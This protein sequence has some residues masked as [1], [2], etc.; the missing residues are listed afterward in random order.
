[1]RLKIM[2]MFAYLAIVLMIVSI[3]PAGAFAAGND[4]DMAPRGAGASND[5]ADKNMTRNQIRDRVNPTDDA[6]RNEVA[7]QTRGAIQ[8]DVAEYRSAKERIVT[9][10]N[11]YSDAKKDFQDIRI[12]INNKK[13]SADSDEVVEATRNYMNQTIEY[14]ITHLETVKE[15]VD[16]ADGD[17]ADEISETIDGYIEQ[18]Q[19]QQEKLE[20]ASTRQEF[21]EIAK[22][23]RSI[24]KDAE[25]RA[26]YFAGKS[27][28]RRLDNYLAKSDALALRIG[29]EI[30]RL[31][32]SGEDVGDLEEM[33]A[34][35][36][37]LIEE[38][39][40]NQE[41]ARETIRNRNGDDDDAVDDANKYMRE[42]TKNI[43][44]ANRV[45]KEIF[46]EL[47]SHRRGGSA[48]LDGAGTLTTEGNGTAV[49]S[50]NLNITINATNAKL[51]I[52]DLA[53]DAEINI[54]GDYTL[55]ND[56]GDDDNNRALVYH[57]FT[58]TVNITGSRLTVMVHGEN[59]SITAEGE[60]S[61]IL[62]GRGSY[63]V[64]KAGKSSENMKWAGDD[65]DDEE[66]DNG[67]GV[68]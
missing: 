6:P 17:N 42:A 25:K 32:E 14:M 2:K 62:S 28:D 13:V 57:N 29:V 49:F 1:M 9:V 59:L 21:A 48:S 37:G 5:D 19:Q 26:K 38:A 50:G 39:K 22:E 66:D 47:K 23:V 56:D 65:S 15:N 36:N 16:N 34:E 68:E 61:S 63:N 20:T 52:K 12:K 60:G 41:L 18:L 43:Q 4:E 30:N 40:W 67:G 54:T 27:V 24:W 46:D 55:V 64:E 33:L 35:Y 7:K 58:G 10:R 53:G 44:D 31:N 11:D 3:L 51:V 45:L 8:S